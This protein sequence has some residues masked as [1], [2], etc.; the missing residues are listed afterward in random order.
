MPEMCSLVRVTD[1]E[2]HGRGVSRMEGL[3]ADPSAKG[4]QRDSEQTPAYLAS[5]LVPTLPDTDDDEDLLERTVAAAFLNV[6]PKTWDSYKKDPRTAPHRQKAG[7]VEH[8]PRGVLLAY[9]ETSAISDGAAHRPEGSG[10]M[11]P[12]DQPRPGR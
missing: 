8:S 12:R 11:V 5:A 10:G 2:L 7:G 1:S 9:Q 6:S 3:D 4:I